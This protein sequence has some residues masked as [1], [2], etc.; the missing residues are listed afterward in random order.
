MDLEEIFDEILSCKRLGAR[1]LDMCREEMEDMDFGGPP[2]CFE[3]FYLLLHPE[4]DRREVGDMI[5]RY[6]EDQ[7]ASRGMA[8]IVAS[9]EPDDLESREFLKNR[10]FSEIHQSEFEYK[11][12]GNREACSLIKKLLSTK[13]R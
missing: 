6:V 8:Y 12:A 4:F 1:A 11:H 7:A 10:G 13:T 5:L 3:I 2:A 9:E